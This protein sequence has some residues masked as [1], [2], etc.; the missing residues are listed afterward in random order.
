MLHCS[1]RIHSI[2]PIKTIPDLKGGTCRAGSSS[3][4]FTVVIGETGL[5]VLDGQEGVVEVQR[6]N[7]VRHL[8]VMG[9][10]RISITQNDVVKPVGAP[11]TLCSSGYEWS[12]TR[13]EHNKTNSFL[14]IV[15]GPITK[16]IF[17]MLIKR[18]YLLPV[19]LGAS[20]PAFFSIINT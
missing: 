8:W 19:W 3:V 17:F 14:I 18:Q 10:T 4:T 5:Q 13:P 2:S 9:T 20:W 1:A 16:A 15:D 12:P 6:G 11:H 7:L